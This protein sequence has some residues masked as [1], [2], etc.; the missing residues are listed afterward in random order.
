M[1]VERKESA[2]SLA[3][4]ESW[5][6]NTQ[7]KRRKGTG[8]VSRLER[9]EAQS[10][11]IRFPS[12]AQDTM[13]MLFQHG[14]PVG[15]VNAGATQ[16]PTTAP[17]LYTPWSSYQHFGTAW[18]NPI[19][20]SSAAPLEARPRGGLDNICS[21]YNLSSQEGPTCVARELSGHSG[22]LSCTTVNARTL[23]THIHGRTL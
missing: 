9:P 7:R 12:N 15:M 22:Y 23:S 2:E 10:E 4:R 8:R 5:R 16:S 13:A 1:R 17:P 11:I 19:S 3:Q 20:K 14:V 6:K 18:V 21:V